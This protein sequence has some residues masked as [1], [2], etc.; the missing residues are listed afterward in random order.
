MAD[1]A[2]VALN[3]SAAAIMA[4]CCVEKQVVNWCRRLFRFPPPPAA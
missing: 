1:I 4:R 2:A 3:A